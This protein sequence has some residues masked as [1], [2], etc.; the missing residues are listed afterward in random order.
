MIGPREMTVALAVLAAIAAG[1]CSRAVGGTPVAAPGDLGTVALLSTTCG[2]YIA[3]RDAQR[4][5]VMAAIGAD[6]NQIV[7]ADPG[8]WSGVAAALCRFADPGAAVR[9]VVTGGVR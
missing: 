3:M 7:A 1:G 4:A 6:G 2:E 5:E 9:D 8:L